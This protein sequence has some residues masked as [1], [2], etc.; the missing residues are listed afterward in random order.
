MDVKG[1]GLEEREEEILLDPF[2]TRET[3][4]NSCYCKRCVYHC[5]LCFLQK[6][7]GINYAS[8]R[9]RRGR[10]G[11]KKKNQIN[12]FDTSEQS[13]SA[14]G[15]NSQSKKEKKEAVEKAVDTNITTGRED[16]FIS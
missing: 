13:L 9:R 14:I 16:I 7:L 11:N 3:S 6:A 1:A 8:R 4:C 2:F 15:R 12:P 5:Q 10:P